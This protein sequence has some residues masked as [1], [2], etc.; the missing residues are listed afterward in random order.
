M[1]NEEKR[2]KLKEI[3]DFLYLT[4]IVIV[5]DGSTDATLKILKKLEPLQRLKL[6]SS[7]INLGK[8]NVLQWAFQELLKDTD[9]SAYDWIGYWDA[10]FSTPID[11]L[12]SMIEF[13]QKNQNLQ[14]IWASRIERDGA[15]INRLWIRFFLGRIFNFISQLLL[16]HSLYDSQCGAKIFSFKAA[17]IGFSEPFISDWPFDLEIYLRLKQNGSFP[18]SEYPVRRWNHVKGSKISLFQDSLKVFWDLIKIRL[19]YFK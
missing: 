5:D 15:Q 4:D 8:G 17:H 19:K 12:T 16:G 13:S 1:Y 18:L 6:L 2:L 11:E 3:S 9:L 7:K 14:A 10:D